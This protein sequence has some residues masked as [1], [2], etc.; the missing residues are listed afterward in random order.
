ML[1]ESDKQ[2]HTF[3]MTTKTNAQE[4]QE[5]QKQDIIHGHDSTVIKAMDSA[6]LACGNDLN[7]SNCLG[8]LTLA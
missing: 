8:P 7:S 3:E 5:L 2:V 1:L 6:P 4:G